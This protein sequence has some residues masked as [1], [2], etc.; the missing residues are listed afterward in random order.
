MLRVEEAV[1]GLV[2]LARLDEAEGVVFLCTSARTFRDCGSSA[3]VAGIRC[4]HWVGRSRE[5]MER[6]DLM[7]D[8]RGLR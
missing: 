7:A 2:D 1:M 3:K 4:L 5:A 8:S 6:V